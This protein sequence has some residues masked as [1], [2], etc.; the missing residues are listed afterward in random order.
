MS[1]AYFQGPYPFATKDEK[2]FTGRNNDITLFLDNGLKPSYNYISLI[3][4]MD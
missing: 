4:E 3:T 1:T 2:S